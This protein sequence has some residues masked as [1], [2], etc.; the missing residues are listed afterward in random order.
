MPFHRTLAIAGFSAAVAG[1]PFHGFASAAEPAGAPDAAGA[2]APTS[3][4]SPPAAAAPPAGATGSLV[5]LEIR[6]AGFDDD[7]GH[8]IGML[9]RPGSNV[10]DKDEAV[11]RTKSEIRNGA[12]LLRF[13]A[14][15]EGTYALVV[16]HDGNDNGVVDHDFL[17]IPSEQLGF[18]NGFRPGLFAGLPTFEKLR[19]RLRRP[20]GGEPVVMELV[21][22]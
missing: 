9:F 1:A 18:S 19:F 3:P 13:P 10:L 16:F 4:S 20:I 17:H 21:V 5:T 8:A 22:K 11:A 7:R 15:E 12:A 14:V 2:T 6:A